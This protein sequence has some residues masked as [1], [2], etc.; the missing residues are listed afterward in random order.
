MRRALLLLP[1]LLLP[2]CGDG[3]DVK[4]AYVADATTVCDEAVADFEALTT[5][6][7]P[8]GFALYADELVGII[9][10]AHEQ[11][12]A[13]TPPEDDRAQLQE[14]AL[15]PLG[16]LVT[17]GEAYAEEVRAAG[18]DQSKLLALLSTRPSG[19]SIDVEY[20]REYGLESC[21]EAVEKAG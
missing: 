5:P 11:L 8:E 20:L 3:E 2:A 6:S 14:R 18:A 7:T 13:L 17:E 9:A 4:A 1:F 12:T 15:D 10:T 21:A 19:K 16:K